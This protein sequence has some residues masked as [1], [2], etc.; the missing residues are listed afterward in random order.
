MFP[1]AEVYNSSALVDHVTPQTWSKRGVNKNHQHH[2]NLSQQSQYR[3]YEHKKEQQQLSPVKKRVKESTPPSNIRNRQHTSPSIIDVSSLWPV[4]SLSQS[5]I[6]HHQPI[7][8][9]Y[10][11]NNLHPQQPEAQGPYIKQQTITIHDTPSPAVSVI[12]ISDSE[13]ESQSKR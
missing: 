6:Q 11:S 8:K 4:Q 3:N 13:E 5:S 10:Q 2:L 12:T 9:L 1:V 7:S